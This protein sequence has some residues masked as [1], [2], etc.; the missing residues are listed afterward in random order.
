MTF[1]KPKPDDT[2]PPMRSA[3]ACVTHDDR[4]IYIEETVRDI[5]TALVGN[6]LGVKGIV[7]RLD[8]VER[9]VDSHDRKL[10]VWGSGFTALWLAIVA[11]KDKLF[12]SH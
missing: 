3:S 1:S 10:L 9:A 12:G 2:I 4:L 6:K 7:P 8:D 11:F 5:K